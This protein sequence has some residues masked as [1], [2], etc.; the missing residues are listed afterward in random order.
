MSGIISLLNETFNITRCIVAQYVSKD[1]EEILLG[2]LAIV[3]LCSCIKFFLKVRIHNALIY[4]YS[5][6]SFEWISDDNM[7]DVSDTGDCRHSAY[8]YVM[9][10][11]YPAGIF[12]WQ[13]AGFTHSAYG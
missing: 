6:D 1:V 11:W 10:E 9:A 7:A 5:S 3:G 12:A 2:F 4:L 13:Y 8:Y